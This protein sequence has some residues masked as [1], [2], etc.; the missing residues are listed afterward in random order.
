[1]VDPS[2]SRVEIRF[3]ITLL[4]SEMIGEGESTEARNGYGACMDSE[5][6]RQNRQTDTQADIQRPA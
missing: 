5:A 2:L 4:C 1:M 3:I 6:K